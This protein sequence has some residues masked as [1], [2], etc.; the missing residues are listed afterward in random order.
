M[1]SDIE[2]L[3]NKIEQKNLKL[4]VNLDRPI[5]KQ[6]EDSIIYRSCRILLI[7]SM[8]NTEKGLSKELIASVDFLLR[9]N[10]YQ[11]KFILEY[12]KE[13]E[14]LDKL[15]SWNKCKNIE[16]DFYLVQ[17]KSVP[18]DLRF[19]D[20][21]LFLSIR[22]LIQQKKTSNKVK[23]KIAEKGIEL[24]GQLQ[25]IFAEESN[26]LNLFNGRIE[27]SKTKRLITEVIPKTYWRENE[28]LSY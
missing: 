5:Y 7:L 4:Y 15:N 16:N 1:N 11:P 27:E 9:N 13:K 12:F 21:F 23:I 26:F 17:Y 24:S 2:L 28:K 20:M 25:R 22:E 14:L 8:I 3:I 19:N 18:W 10:K 6:P